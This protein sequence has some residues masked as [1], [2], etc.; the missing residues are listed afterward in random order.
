MQLFS[1]QGEYLKAIST[2][3]LTGPTT[4][5]F[6]RSSDLIVLASRG[7][8]CFNESGKCVKNITNKHLNKPYGSLTIA[9]D[10]HVVV[11]D[12]NNIEK[13]LTPDGSELLL[14]ISDPDRVRPTYA[15]CHQDTFVVSYYW[16]DNVKIFSKDGLFMY[17][18]GTPGS[19]DGQLCRPAGLI[20]DRFSSLVVCGSYN[21]RL[22]IFTIEGKFLSTIGG[23][24]TSLTVDPRH[25]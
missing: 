11:C 2:K 1:S 5:A 22:Q 3:E 24:H 21:S 19:G 17:R 18:I 25:A 9:R 6:T 20:N 13:V 14:T 15:V 7:I 8:F 4:V 16:A 12:G 23:Q 10:G